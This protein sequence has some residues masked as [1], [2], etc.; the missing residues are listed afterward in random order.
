[1]RKFLKFWLPA[2]LY[3]IL[4]FIVS[5]FE[6]PF[7][8]GL[9]ATGLDKLAHFLEYAIF[10]FL[11]ARAVRGSDEKLSRGLVVSIAFAIGALY[12][13]TDELHQSV[14]PGRCAAISD[15]F[16]DALGSLAGAAAFFLLL[17]NRRMSA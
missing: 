7:T 2:V 1:M 10:G 16:M 8:A 15:F 9:E 12:G 4:I 11:M 5:S 17:K 6:W 14:I 3:A 13:I